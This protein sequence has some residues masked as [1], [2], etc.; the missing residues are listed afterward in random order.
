MCSAEVRPVLSFP[1]AGILRGEHVDPGETVAQALA[2]E[3]VEE[4][5]WILAK[6]LV[7]LPPKSWHAAD[8]NR[9]ERQFVVTVKG[10]LTRPTLEDGKV[11]LWRWIGAG[12]LPILLENRGDID[13]LIDDS[14]K[15]AFDFL[16]NS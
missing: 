9:L 12:D 10:D 7:E 2:R 3:V 8:G 14:I 16:D 13:T 11:D 4:T 15:E 1:A 6:T 5:G